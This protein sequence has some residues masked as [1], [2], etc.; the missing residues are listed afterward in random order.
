MQIQTGKCYNLDCEIG[1]KAMQEQGLIADWCITDVPYGINITEKTEKA[2]GTRYG[3]GRARKRI[4]ECGDWDKRRIDDSYFDLMRSVSKNQIIF[5]GG[6]YTNIL[7]PTGGWIVWDKKAYNLADRN[8]YGD[9]ELAWSNT[10]TM[11]IFRYHFT[12]MIQGDARNKDKRF[13]PTQ[14]PTQIWSQLL[15]Y[16]TKEGDI[17]LD[18][19]AGSQSLHIACIRLN[20]R[21]IGFEIDKGYYDKGCEWVELEKRQKTI[22]EL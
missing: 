1:M 12:G 21:Y 5:G 13:H 17:V 22:W 16:Y 6:Y 4:Y 9:C 19:F 20:R 2:N 11:R 15:E 3:N 7:P 18:A 14:K 10:N 8:C